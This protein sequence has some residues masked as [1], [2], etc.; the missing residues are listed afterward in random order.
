M[1]MDHEEVQAELE[2]I[3]VSCKLSRRELAELRRHFGA[4]LTAAW[5]LVKQ[6]RVKKYVFKPSGRVQWIVAGNARDYLI[7][8]HAPYCHC[9]SFYLSIMGGKA[10]ACKH[11][12]A[13]RLASQLGLY[14]L[15]EEND[16]NYPKLLE[17]WRQVEE[18]TRRPKRLEAYPEPARL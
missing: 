7:Y 1:K 14:E 10:K 6:G 17:E 9:S 15:V 4:R 5:R 18:Q 11:L 16:E 8:E 2:R 13:Q 3:R 12:I